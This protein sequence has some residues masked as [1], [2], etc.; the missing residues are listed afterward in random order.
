VSKLLKRILTQKVVTEPLPPAA[1]LEVVGPRLA[2]AVRRRF[3]GALAVRHLDAGSCNGCELEIH[4]CNNPYYDLERFGVHFVASPR[5]AD[6]LLV[7]GPLTRNMKIAV[8]RTFAAVPAPKRVVA[9]G[10]CA[11]D[12]GPFAPSYAV[13]GGVDAV[14][15]V[16]VWVPGCPPSPAAI[17][18]GILAAVEGSAASAV[19]SRAPSAGR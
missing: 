17:I 9:V 11:R 12:G 5:L 2:E 13:L 1:G 4:A 10:G 16:D 15:P 8:E 19:A 7:T 3:A 6:L 18:R 14:L